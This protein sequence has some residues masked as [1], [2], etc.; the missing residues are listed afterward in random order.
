M[1]PAAEIECPIEIMPGFSHAHRIHIRNNSCKV[2]QIQNTFAYISYFNRTSGGGSY[3]RGEF[4][5]ILPL[6]WSNF[7]DTSVTEDF[8]LFTSHEEEGEGGRQLEFKLLI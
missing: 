4:S 7:T 3:P 5:I 8:E 2:M 6:K 1:H